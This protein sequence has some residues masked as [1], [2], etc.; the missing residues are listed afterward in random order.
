MAGG[1]PFCMIP[2][3]IQK[4]RIKFAAAILGDSYSAGG[5]SSLVTP[6]FNQVTD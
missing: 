2:E 1:K 5:E 6:E 3:F 4:P